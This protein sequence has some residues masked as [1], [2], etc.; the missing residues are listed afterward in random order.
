MDNL[1][2]KENWNKMAN[3]YEGPGMEIEIDIK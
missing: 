3:E 2:I 1:G